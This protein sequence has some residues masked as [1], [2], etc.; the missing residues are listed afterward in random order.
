[1]SSKPDILQE[2]KNLTR[3]YVRKGGKKNRRQQHKRML[4][5]GLFCRDNLQ[6]PNLATVGKRHVVRYYKSIENLSD[7]TRLSHYYAIKTL[8]LLAGKAMPVKPFP[9]PNPEIDS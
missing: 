6:A 7:A 4:E 1:M 5:F 8:F 9:G 2:I 3:D